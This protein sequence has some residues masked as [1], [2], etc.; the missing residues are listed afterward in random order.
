MEPNDFCSIIRHLNFP[1]GLDLFATFGDSPEL[2][3]A[4]LVITR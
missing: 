2:Q 1:H 4:A 3:K